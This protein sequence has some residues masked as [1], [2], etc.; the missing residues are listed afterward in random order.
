MSDAN[1]PT[2]EEFKAY[3]AQWQTACREKDRDHI[4]PMLPADMPDDFVGQLMAQYN[5][6]E[7]GLSDSGIEPRVEQEGISY[8]MVYEGELPDGMTMM[9]EDFFFVDG[10]W[11]KYDPAEEQ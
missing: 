3:Y 5:A 11:L 10:Q 4:R 7:K 1:L 9:T 2:E 8:K 6:M